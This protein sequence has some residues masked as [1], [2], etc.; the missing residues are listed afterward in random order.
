LVRVVRATQVVRLVT[1]A[2]RP[3][4]RGEEVVVLRGL[5]QA[6]LT[7]GTTPATSWTAASRSG[8][9]RDDVP[10]RSGEPPTPSTRG[11]T[12][13]REPSRLSR[14]RPSSAGL[15]RGPSPTIPQPRSATAVPRTIPTPPRPV[16]R[17]PRRQL[18]QP[19]QLRAPTSAR[20]TP[21]TR[22]RIRSLPQRTTHRLLSRAP[23]HAH[24]PVVRTN[25]V[26]ARQ[27]YRPTRYLR[28]RPATYP[29]RLVPADPRTHPRTYLPTY[30]PT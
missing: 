2:V 7:R 16:A 17:C 28:S 8:V 1:A 4:V 10:A 18:T 9:R 24:P 12:R 29:P 6:L 19:R 21:S 30:L 26:P 23:H 20:P 27:R 3:P 13:T 15:K 22:G 11:A 14:P 25:L 5:A